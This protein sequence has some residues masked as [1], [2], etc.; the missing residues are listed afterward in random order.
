MNLVFASDLHLSV[1]EKWSLNVLEELLLKAS[2]KSQYLFLGGD[3][4][5]SFDDL[6]KLK[7]DFIKKVEK[8]NL[9]RV[10]FLPGNHDIAGATLEKLNEIDF[11]KKICLM[12]KTPFLFDLINDIEFL[13]IPFQKDFSELY[14][15]SEEKRAFRVVIGHGSVEGDFLNNE[16]ENNA[17]FSRNLFKLL[18]ADLVLLGHIH[19]G[20]EINNIL[21]PGSARVWRMGEEGPHGFLVYSTDN[22]QKEIIPLENAGKYEVIELNIEEDK[23]SLID[24]EDLN[25]ENV[26]LEIVFNGFVNNV[27]VLDNIKR[28]IEAKFDKAKTKFNEDK[29][30]IA[31]NVY[32]SQLFK[33]FMEKWHNYYKNEVNQEEKEILLLSRRYFI[34]ELNELRKGGKN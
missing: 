20:R 18:D 7:D 21:Y 23:Y 4:F 34:E 9:E 30:I 16:E 11:G 8:S 22:R 17:I 19:K 26:F 15:F 1:K 33:L 14:L 12:S 32:N 25:K 10:Y 13:F 27:T 6:L 24:K 28:K 2:K 3:V 5:D 29:I 31:E